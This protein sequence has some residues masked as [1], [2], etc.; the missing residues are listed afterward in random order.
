[1]QGSPPRPRIAGLQ[2]RPQKLI[3]RMG[4]PVG[5]DLDLQVSHDFIGIS[6]C[7]KGRVK[8][9]MDTASRRFVVGAFSRITVDRSD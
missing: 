3:R 1:M 7:K 5:A 2:T 8:E 9:Q 4:P 6:A